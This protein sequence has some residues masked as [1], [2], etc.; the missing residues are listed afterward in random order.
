MDG[1]I[2]KR[3]MF[4]SQIDNFWHDISGEEYA[5]LDIKK[6][7]VK[8][9]ERLRLATE[10][11]GH[12]FYKTAPLLR[13]LDNETFARLG[14]PRETHAFLRLKTTPIESVIARLDLVVM[15]DKIK[16]LELNADTPTFIKETFY[17]NGKVC[18]YFQ[19]ENPNAGYEEQLR[20]AL[21]TAVTYCAP[22]K[23]S[24]IIFASHPDNEEDKHT[25][26]Y[27]KELLE[28]DSRYMDFNQLR[29]V[30]EPIIE[31]R[32]IILSPG[33]YDANGNK[34]DLLYRQTYPIEH[35]I[36]DEDPLTKEKVGQMLMKLVEQKELAILNPPS[37]FLLQSKA[38]MAL[39]WGLHEERHSFYTQEEHEIIERYFL[40][41]Y[42]D[43]DEFLHKGQT[44][45]KKPAFGREGDTV[46][47]YS[48]TGTKV[49]EDT[50]K[51]YQEELSVY[52][53]FIELPQ[54]DIQTV[55]GPK[56]AHYMYGSFY[57][58]GEASA[59]GV[60]AGGQITDN[61]SYFLPIGI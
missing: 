11:I 40:A 30:N 49:A 9:I 60:R 44:Y 47:I 31:S 32:Q 36:H 55:Q 15:G 39:I 35:L 33:L 41:T 16:L 10:Q 58:N 50:H 12:I 19:M 48:S 46:E 51:T 37:A 38:I 56:R 13:R 26:L 57:I 21:L 17:V 43:P 59:I 23:G 22:I 4:Y 61:T 53:E 18:D 8:N 24:N 34:I 28:I 14:F 25:T 3:Q 20:K 27:L 54:I 7:S 45:V 42:L 1:F 52:Q 2:E 5:L 6:E 29:I